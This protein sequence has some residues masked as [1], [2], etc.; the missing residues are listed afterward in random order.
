MIKAKLLL[1]PLNKL[2]RFKNFDLI[3]A[4]E[5]GKRKRFEQCNIILPSILRDEHT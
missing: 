2:Q 3:L 1:D 5:I 4:K